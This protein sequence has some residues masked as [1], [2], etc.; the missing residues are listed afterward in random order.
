VVFGHL[1]DGYLEGVGHPLP[2]ACLDKPAGF[3]KRYSMSS[4]DFRP[5]FINSIV[6]VTIRAHAEDVEV[7]SAA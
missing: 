2:I 6:S 5:V 3:L 7:I 4:F 1:L